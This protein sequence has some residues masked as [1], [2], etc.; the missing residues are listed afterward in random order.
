MKFMKTAGYYQCGNI[1]HVVRWEKICNGDTYGDCRDGS[2]ESVEFCERF[3]CDLGMWKCASDKK[4][5]RG[6]FGVQ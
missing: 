4:V 5:Y 1:T 6:K 2:D 3:K